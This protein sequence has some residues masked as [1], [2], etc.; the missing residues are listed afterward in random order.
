MRSGRPGP[1]TS[2]RR[3]RRLDDLAMRL[4]DRP[5]LGSQPR[6]ELLARP[7]G[8]AEVAPARSVAVARDPTLALEVRAARGA[9]GDR[10]NEEQDV[11]LVEVGLDRPGDTVDRDVLAAHL[12]GHRLGVF[13]V[14]LVAA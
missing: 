5:A 2:Q 1:T 11:T 7:I 10:V 12:E 9:V 3:R 6:Q 4:D 8:V 14:R 13:E